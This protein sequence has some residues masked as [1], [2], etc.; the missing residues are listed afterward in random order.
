MTRRSDTDREP[1]APCQRCG[2]PVFVSW[3][4]RDHPEHARC[5]TCA[6]LDQAEAEK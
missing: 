2:R 3:K 1:V 4:L 6:L 5:H